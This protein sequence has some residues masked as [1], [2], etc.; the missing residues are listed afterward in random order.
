MNACPYY[1]LSILMISFFA[2]LSS[3]ITVITFWKK[4]RGV[5]YWAAGY[6]FYFLSMLTVIVFDWFS[7]STKMVVLLILEGL[8]GYLQFLGFLRYFGANKRR[9]EIAFFVFFVAASLA[10]SFFHGDAN[11]P[12]VSLFKNLT[13]AVPTA[14]LLY[15]VCRHKKIDTLI[16]VPTLL[17]FCAI[18]SVACFFSAGILLESSAR[19]DIAFYR[20]AERSKLVMGVVF[21]T[22]LVFSQNQLANSYLQRSISKSYETLLAAQHTIRVANI[23]LENTKNNLVNI[24]SESL[25]S[26]L[27]ETSNHV[28]RV[29]CFTRVI[30]D[31]I[32]YTEPDKEDIIIAASLHDIGKIGIPDHVLQTSRVYTDREMRIMQ[33]HTTIGYDILS[34]SKTNFLQLAAVIALEHHENWDGSGY[35][36]GKTGNEIAFP[37]R[38][39][40]VADTF[41]ALVN[42]R[43]YK[44]AWTVGEAMSYIRMNSGKKFDSEIVGVLPDCLE[45]F[46]TIL[47][48][49][50]P[51]E[52]ERADDTE[53]S[54]LVSL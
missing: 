41:D 42:A 46:R 11:L 17:V 28:R 7:V 47:W 16:Q 18:V 36:L 51:V 12:V 45:E 19:V 32:G 44:K 53:I 9:A 43:R 40:S 30:L 52:K 48:N 39:V 49:N 25:E 5:V 35:P 31:S 21:L 23:E 22:V 8:G 24:V 29:S 2:F 50:R 4:V 33:A 37:S 15:F 10:A 34:Q 54:P 3:L 26:R 1:H 27:S 20:L 6:F 14:Y 13:L 38:V